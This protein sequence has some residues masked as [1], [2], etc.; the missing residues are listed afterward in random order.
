MHY[1]EQ[2][3]GAVTPQLSFI[4]VKFHCGPGNLQK[5]GSFFPKAT[6]AAP[7][8]PEFF[9]PE[10]TPEKGNALWKGCSPSCCHH[11]CFLP[12]PVPSSALNDAPPLLLGNQRTPA[13]AH[14]Q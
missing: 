4:R 7:F 5:T 14:R 10:G 8:F 3:L 12:F 9:T 1:L 13:P 6:Q 11:R 2:K